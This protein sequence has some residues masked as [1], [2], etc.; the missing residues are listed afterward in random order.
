MPSS[1]AP[2]LQRPCSPRSP[3]SSRSAGSPMAWPPAPSPAARS[4]TG[5]CAPRTCATAA[6][7]GATSPTDRS[8]AATC[9]TEPF[10]A[11]TS[12]TAPRR[13]RTW[14]RTRSAT[15]R[16]T[17]PPWTSSA[18]AALTPPVSSRTSGASRPPRA[19]DPDHPKATAA[20]ELPDG[21]APAGRRRASGGAG[22]NTPVAL[23]VERPRRQRLG[24]L[25]LRH[26]RHRQLAARLHGDLRL[27]GRG[28]R[29]REHR[30][31][32]GARSPTSGKIRVERIAAPTSEAA[33][34]ARM[35]PCSTAIVVIATTSGSSVD[36]KKASARRARA[37]ST[38]R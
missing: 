28:W 18:S 20:S 34:E 10:A 15:A 12:T 5:P 1:S 3:C 14:P 19:N 25:R 26:R 11:W 33:V 29:A 16:S 37:S 4:R 23:T 31:G 17:S 27:G 32:A 9:G 36:E 2:S 13:P 6:S 38:P 8:K 22:R 21:Q 24:G 35:C 7:S 30:L